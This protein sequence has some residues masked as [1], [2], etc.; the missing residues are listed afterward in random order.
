MMK[1]PHHFQTGFTLVETLVAITILLIVITG[2]MT[3]S[4]STARST[5]FASEQV[6]AFFLAQEG[7]EIAQKLRDEELLPALPGPGWNDFAD[8]SGT[9][10]LCFAITGCGLELNTDDDASPKAVKNCAGGACKLYYESGGL[11]SRYT[12][13]SVGTESTPFT[14]TITFTQVT[15]SDVKV[16]SSVTWRTGTLRKIQEVKVET[17]LFDVY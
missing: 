4:M 16:V 17:H 1:K 11:R 5:S 12:H 6:T 14:R 8:T 13:Q 15:P 7:A 2:P 3:I 9:Y 10:L